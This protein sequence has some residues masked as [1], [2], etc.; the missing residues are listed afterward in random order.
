MLE[1]KIPGFGR[2]NIEHLVLDY[3]GTIAQDGRLIDGASER[4]KKLSEKV[5]VHIITAD[6][7]NSAKD[8]PG[9]E[10]FTLKILTKE[11]QAQ[12]KKTYLESLGSNCTV[13]IGNGNND[14]LMLSA[15][16]I[17]IVTIQAE[18]ASSKAIC[19]GDIAVSDINSAL[20]LLL[21]PKRLIATLRE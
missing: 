12:Q 20:D 19:N 14:R 9:R 6:T 5:Q 21:F 17:G 15:S 16:I 2:L 18:G 3:N 8:Y 11:N 4:L 1:L 13:A 7:F 10:P